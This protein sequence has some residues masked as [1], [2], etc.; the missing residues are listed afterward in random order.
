MGKEASITIDR[1]VLRAREGATVMEAADTAGIYI[2]RLCYHPALPPGPGTKAVHRVFRHGEIDADPNS[3]DNTYAGCNICIVEIEGRG[4]SPSCTTPVEDGMAIRTKSAALKEMRRDNLARILAHHP[5]ACFVC[6]EQEGCDR[7]EC[8]MGV[9]EDCR[10]CAK[11]DDCEFRQ[12][13]GH[14][15]LKEDISQ[16]AFRNIPV[17]NTPFFTYDA[18]LC[19]GCTRCVR[20]CEK[21]EGKRVIGFALRKGEIIVGTVGPSHRESG[22]AFCGACV[23]VCPT[24]ALMDKGLAWKKKAELRLAPVIL[25][26]E[27]DLAMTE[28]NVAKV[29]EVNGVYQLFDDKQ[30]VIYIRGTDN[31]RRDLQEKWKS[32]AKARFFRYEEHGM[33]TMRETEMLEHFLK[34]HGKLPEVNDEIADLY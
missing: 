28:E 3:H 14:V 15:T 25:P 19:I 6:A 23:T 34:K 1:H 22:C 18:N 12:V 5:H 4:T 31:V 26:P 13:C 32:V 7:E 11:F 16:Y 10:C 27:D 21:T 24:G 9:D 17:V 29:P 8:T 30:E 33:Y 2:P 20:A